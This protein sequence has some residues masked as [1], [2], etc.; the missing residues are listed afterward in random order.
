VTKRQREFAQAV[1]RRVSDKFLLGLVRAWLGAGVMVG[2]SVEASA[3]GTPQ[4]GV[5]SRLLAKL[6]LHQ[7]DAEWH[8][9]DLTLRSGANAQFVRYADDFVILSDKSV[10]GLVPV[11]QEILGS[12]GLR[13]NMEKFRG[14]MADNG[15]D[16]LGF[17]FVRRPSERHG[18]RKMTYFFPSPRSVE[19]V[20]E[21]V[22]ELCGRH[23]LHAPPVDVVLSM[24]RLLVGW[25]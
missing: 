11:V 15:F 23:L 25:R 22:R 17:R 10:R 5:I 4:G 24:N 20:K 19:R 1:A 2:G 14:V 12:L 21:K 7:L 6:Y 3:V 8:G 9:R 13:L 18:G 16:F